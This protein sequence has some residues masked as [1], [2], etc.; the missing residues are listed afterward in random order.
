MRERQVELPDLGNPASSWGLGF[1][2]WETPA[3]LVIG[4]DGATIGQV[5]FLRIVPGGGDAGVA[6]ALLTN[7]G[8]SVSL[9]HDVMGHLLA[10]LAGADLPPLPVPPPEPEPVDA[11]R[12][13]GTYSCDVGD[14]AV[15][16]DHQGRVWA[17]EIPKG[18][19]IEM[20]DVEQRYELVSLRDDTLIRLEPELGMYRTYAFLGED[21]SGHSLY[22]HVGR[23][24]RRAGV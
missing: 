9:Y 4:H 17:T 18:V 13:L 21:G 20:G 1:E 10:E 6:V 8:N 24:I 14:I 15:T 2:R 11:A 22:A 7:G 23:A 12:Y 19:A 16:Q 5:A 3:G